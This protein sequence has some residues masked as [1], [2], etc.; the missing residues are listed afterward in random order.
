MEQVGPEDKELVAEW[1]VCMARECDMRMPDPA[2][3]MREYV[4]RGE[5]FLWRDGPV[6]AMTTAVRGTPSGCRIAMVYTPPELRHRGYASAL[7]A[8]L[9]EHKLN[10][11][12]RRCFLFTDSQNPTSNHIY[13]EIGYRPICNFDTYEFLP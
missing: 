5:T 2:Q 13:S 9:S 6:A 8:Q 7:V 3:K 1:G 10:N 4:N 11:G 12:C